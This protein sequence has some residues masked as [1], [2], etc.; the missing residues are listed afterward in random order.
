MPHLLPQQ[1]RD[2]DVVELS[3]VLLSLEED[4]TTPSFYVAGQPI[5]AD[6]AERAIASLVNSGTS[7]A[8]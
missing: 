7:V 3:G 6:Q 2:A 5:T 8:R 4:A 1:V